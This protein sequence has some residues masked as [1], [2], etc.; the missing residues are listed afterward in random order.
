MFGTRSVALLIVCFAVIAIADQHVGE[1]VIEHSTK[2]NETAIEIPV[3]DQEAQS[4][5]KALSEEAQL[6]KVLNDATAVSADAKVD[7]IAKTVEEV[8]RRQKRGAKH[9]KK[10]NKGG[11]R[12]ASPKRKNRKNGRKKQN[13]KQLRD[14]RR[15]QRLQRQ[16][17]KRINKA[18]KARNAVLKK[19]KN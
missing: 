1:A 15:M 11:K 8:A 5:T 13:R 3:N 18:K 19:K 10:H 7:P 16:S 12:K 4:A 6:P 17:L 2:Q 9:K 14:L